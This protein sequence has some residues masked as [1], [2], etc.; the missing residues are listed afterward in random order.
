MSPRS[1]EHSSESRLSLQAVT[2]YYHQFSYPTLAADI[3]QQLER[4][5]VGEFYWV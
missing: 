2:D 5:E 1:P 4:L 3:H